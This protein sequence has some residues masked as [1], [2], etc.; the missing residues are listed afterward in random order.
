MTDKS[1]WRH[2]NADVLAR[3]W[4]GEN[5]GV[6]FHTPGDGW[7]D[8]KG[9]P[10]G[11]DGLEY[12]DKP[13]PRDQLKVD[14]PILVKN[15]CDDTWSA[16][17]FAK[18]SSND[19]GV[20]C[21]VYGK[22]SWNASEAGVW[23]W[24]EWKLPEDDSDQDQRDKLKVDQPILVK[25]KNDD[26]WYRQHFAKK[27]SKDDGVYCWLYGRTS[28]TASEDEIACWNEWKLP[29]NELDQDP[30]DKLKVDHKRNP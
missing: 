14:Q 7:V 20:Y 5:L 11:H 10:V 3:Y 1:K 28:W 15:E 18:K 17:H 6:Q 22:T 30:R 4:L 29:E 19:D 13:D 25:D 26:V 8:C 12:R 24:E 27:S 9:A 23:H 16:Y 21:W 2:P